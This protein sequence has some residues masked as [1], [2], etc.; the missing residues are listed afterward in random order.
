MVIDLNSV[1]GCLKYYVYYGT[2][3]SQLLDFVTFIIL[4][5]GIYLI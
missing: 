4:D 1:E 5:F 2:N 3:S